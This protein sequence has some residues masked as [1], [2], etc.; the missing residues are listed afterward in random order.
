MVQMM[1]AINSNFSGCGP[2]SSGWGKG[3]L[4]D[5]PS[6]SPKIILF[7]PSSQL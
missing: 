4:D 5:R 3:Y 1:A 2:F 6:S 7:E